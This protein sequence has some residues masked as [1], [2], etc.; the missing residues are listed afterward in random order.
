MRSFST[1][2][3][4]LLP[5]ASFVSFA[6]GIELNPDNEASLKAA[7][8]QYAHTLLTYYKGNVSGLPKEEVGVFPKPPYYWWEAGAAWGGMIEY[9]SFT[10]DASYVELLHQALVGNYGP[11]NDIL[12]PWKTDQE[13]N[14]DQAFWALALMSALEYQFPEPSEA[15][16]T[17]LEVVENCFNNIVPRWDLSSCNGGFKWQIYPENAYGW[18]Y[19]NSISNGAV[20]SL[21]ARLAR[22]TGNQTYVD[23]A[24]KIW[25]WSTAIGLITDKYEV[26]DGTDDKLNCTDHDDTQW[27]YNIGIYLHG[28]AVLY[29]HTNGDE[30]WKKHTNGFIDHAAAFFQ[31]FDNATDIMYEVACET[32]ETGRKCNVDQMSFKAYLSRFLAKTAI[33]APFSKDKVTNWLRKSA[34]GAAKSCSGGADGKTCGLRWY[35]GN[36]DGTDGVGQQ[37]AALEV[38]QSLLMLMKGVI[39]SVGGDIKPSPSSSATPIG[40]STYTTIVVPS[41]TIVASTSQSTATPEAP[42]EPLPSSGTAVTSISSSSVAAPTSAVGAVSTS[43]PGGAFFENGPSTSGVCTC[44]PSSTITVY[45]PPT[46]LA[47]PTPSLPATAN[48]TVPSS[49]PAN[50]TGPELF[51]GAAA[52][53]KVTSLS[54]VAAAAVVFVSVLL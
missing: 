36:W 33:M 51:P 40:S 3:A 12:I 38:T 39:P 10:G 52:N 21:A 4:A 7:T 25:D 17:Y 9:T 53:T 14:D 23:W 41:S 28:A 46:T 20:F 30:K 32:E 45:V 13:G 54:L 19:K 2:G 16:A 31:P 47:T 22:Y 34:I 8:A 15:P 26:F 29:N 6:R 27:S 11:S 42:K 49:P 50:T 48:I 24:E 35:T 5:F 43:Q 18:N 37:L 44:T 1:I